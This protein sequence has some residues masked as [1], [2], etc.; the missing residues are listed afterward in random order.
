ML[1]LEFQPDT[2]ELADR[3]VEYEWT[4]RQFGERY[5]LILH[6]FLK[7]DNKNTQFFQAMTKSAMDSKHNIE[8]SYTEDFDGHDM[9]VCGIQNW[10]AQALKNTLV[11][12]IQ[13]HYAQSDDNPQSQTKS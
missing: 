7:E 6:F 10:Q 2:I 1:E 5:D 3:T 4:T 11:S 8:V 13:K 12:G 9:I